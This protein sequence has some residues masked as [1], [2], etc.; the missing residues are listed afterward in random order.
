MGPKKKPEG[1]KGNSFWQ[2]DAKQDLRFKF[3]IQ[4]KPRAKD[5]SASASSSL[6]NPLGLPL[7]IFI[8]FEISLCVFKTNKI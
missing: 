2:V 6:S 3:K 5:N 4:H 1:W 7:Y 8:S